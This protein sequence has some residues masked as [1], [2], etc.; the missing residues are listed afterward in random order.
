MIVISKSQSCSQA[1]SSGS[2]GSRNCDAG[3]DQK[4][5]FGWQLQ[6]CKG[7]LLG[8]AGA[9]DRDIAVSND[10]AEPFQQSPSRESRRRKENRSIPGDRRGGEPGRVPRMQDVELFA[11]QR[12]TSRNRMTIVRSVS[13]PACLD[14]KF[15]G[16]SALQQR[17]CLIGLEIAA[18]AGEVKHPNHAGQRLRCEARNVKHLYCYG[19]AMELI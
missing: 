8:G 12:P 19:F 14:G 4:A 3:P 9:H 17:R 16:Q 5:S 18:L 1:R 7:A 2:C 6:R 11:A 13:N 10:G 15:P